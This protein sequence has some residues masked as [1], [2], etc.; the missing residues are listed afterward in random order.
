MIRPQPAQTPRRPGPKPPRQAAPQAPLGKPGRGQAWRSS[1]PPWR[2]P[3]P[4]QPPQGPLRRPAALPG[5]A[6]RQTPTGGRGFASAAPLR[7]GGPAPGRRPRPARH[8]RSY[9]SRDSNR[10]PPHPQQHC[11]CTR[12]QRL[13]ADGVEAASALSRRSPLPSPF[14]FKG[15]RKGGGKGRSRRE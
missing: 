12:P 8:A 9:P 6:P 5:A 13:E 3:S 2:P 10:R 11:A 7:G 1:V 15:T 4:L 14:P